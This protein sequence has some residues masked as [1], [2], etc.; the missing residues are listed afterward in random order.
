MVKI[1]PFSPVKKEQTESKIPTL[2]STAGQQQRRQHKPSFLGSPQHSITKHL[3]HLVLGTI[4]PF[5]AVL[6]LPSTST[7][8]WKQQLSW[9]SICSHHTDSLPFSHTFLSLSLSLLD[10]SC[11]FIPPP[12]PRHLTSTQPIKALQEW[13]LLCSNKVSK[14][15][16]FEQKLWVHHLRRQQEEGARVHP[17]RLSTNKKRPKNG[18][19]ASKALQRTAGKALFLILRSI[20][21]HVSVLPV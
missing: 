11:Y 18:L 15:Q 14:H 7:R 19:A 10:E 5:L 1:L 12:W 9:G 20:K 3:T 2:L 21:I 17:Q 16:G 13:K 8:T 4:L 6:C